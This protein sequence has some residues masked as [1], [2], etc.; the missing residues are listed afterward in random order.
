MR[1]ETPRAGEPLI[2]DI[3]STHGVWK[4]LDSTHRGFPHTGTR[5][6]ATLWSQALLFTLALLTDEDSATTHRLTAFHCFRRLWSDR[7]SSSVSQ[8]SP[9]AGLAELLL[10]SRCRSVLVDG[11]S[12]VIVVPA[13][14]EQHEQSSSSRLRAR[15]GR[16]DPRLWLW[17]PR[18]RRP[19]CIPFCRQTEERIG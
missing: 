9:K 1:D 6:R 18:M 8:D 3:R 10:T 14:A 17:A 15:L 16:R 5:A 7:P 12:L 2:R 13:R 11:A 19:G 4:E